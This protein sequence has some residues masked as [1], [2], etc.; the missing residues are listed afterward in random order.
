MKVTA[1]YIKDKTVYYLEYASFI[2]LFK[3]PKDGQKVW[4]QYRKKLETEPK[5]YKSGVYIEGIINNTQCIFSHGLSIVDLQK[6]LDTFIKN[7]VKEITIG[8][9]TTKYKKDK[10]IFNEDLKIYIKEMYPVSEILT[11]P[12]GKMIQD[13]LDFKKKFI[14]LDGDIVKITSDRLKLFKTKGV[15]CCKCGL[16]GKWFYKIRNAS[17]LS[18]HLEL[19]GEKDGKLVV[20]TKDHI[21]PLSKGGADHLSNLQT[22]CGPCNWAK[23]NKENLTDKFTGISAEEINRAKLN[24][25]HALCH[26]NKFSKMQKTELCS[27]ILRIIDGRSEEHFE[28]PNLLERVKKIFRKS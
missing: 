13:T 4:N 18:Y 11:G 10:E 20:F 26:K 2:G 14:S 19:F 21:Q 9:F 7:K 12:I 27:E 22:M 8:E 15:K 28:K 1:H 5:Y 17:D 16:E 23:S 24:A 3:N 6:R 25:I